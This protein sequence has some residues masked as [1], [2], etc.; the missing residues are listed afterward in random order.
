MKTREKIY[1]ELFASQRVELALIDDI[2]SSLKKSF[3][4]I[5]SQSQIIAIENKVKK[6]L[7]EAQVALKLSENGLQKA[8]ELGA[9]DFIKMMEKKVQ[10]AKEQISLAN[11]IISG[12]SK[13]I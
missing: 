1:K 7:S 8:K 12:L 10:E 9:S 11:S 3:D 4:L 6:G 2:N 5:E 13:L